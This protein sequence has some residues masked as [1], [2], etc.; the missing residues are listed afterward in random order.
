MFVISWVRNA[1][2]P[3][4]LSSLGPQSLHRAQVHRAQWAIANSYWPSLERSPKGSK[5]G[6]AV[7]DM[8]LFKFLTHK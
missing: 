5:E 1:S 4:L 7:F 2:G 8:I 3:I 6:Y